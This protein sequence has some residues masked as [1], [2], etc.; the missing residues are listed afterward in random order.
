MS[1]PGSGRYTTYV[2][3]ASNRNTMLRNLFNARASNEAGTFY[4]KVDETDN[5]KAAAAAV[6]TAVAPVAATGIGGVIPSAG[7]QAGDP[8]MFPTGV[9]LSFG[10]SPNLTEVVWGSAGGPAN[11]YTPDLSSPGPGKTLGVEKDSDPK[12]TVAD[13]KGEK[14]VPGAPG[15]GTTSPNTTSPVVG[16]TPIGKSL[17][18]GK[19]SV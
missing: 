6:V 13:V 8:G 1:G 4:G 19:S 5:I 18:M 15:T 10:N 12:I 17:Q 14:Y 9:D 2:P 3:V 16:S 7:L 11:P